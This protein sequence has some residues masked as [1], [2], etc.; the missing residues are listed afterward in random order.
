M[1]LDMLATSTAAFGLIRTLGGTVGISVGGA[2]YS[3]E[4]QNRIKSLTASG[5]ITPGA[6]G[7]DLG[8]ITRNVRQ[9][10]DIPVSHV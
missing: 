4:V 8:T 3:S 2:I 10:A 6:N 1:P 9:I 7:L 5:A